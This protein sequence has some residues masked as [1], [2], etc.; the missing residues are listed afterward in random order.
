MNLLLLLD[1]AASGRGDEVD[2]GAPAAQ[3]DEGRDQQQGEAVEQRGPVRGVEIY[4][5]RNISP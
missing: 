1:M 2:R 5:K 4:R 3:L